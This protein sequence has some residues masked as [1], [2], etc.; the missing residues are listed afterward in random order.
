MPQTGMAAELLQRSGRDGK[1]IMGDTLTWLMQ[2]EGEAEAAFSPRT[3]PLR[4]AS[5]ESEND[6]NCQRDS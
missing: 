5:I 1:Q 2:A 3:R 4:T 6:L